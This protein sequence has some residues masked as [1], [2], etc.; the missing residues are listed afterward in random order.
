M[1]TQNYSGPRSN[2]YILEFLSR[3]TNSSVFPITDIQHCR[4]LSLAVPATGTAR[5]NFS[6]RRVLTHHDKDF[7]WLTASTPRDNVRAA[8]RTATIDHGRLKIRTGVKSST[9]CRRRPPQYI[10][11]ACTTCAKAT[12]A[13][14]SDQRERIIGD[15]KQME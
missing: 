7:N 5:E 6:R 13:S 2:I 4:R 11:D 12:S 10:G 3:F 1:K 14:K 9:D 15:N 8:K